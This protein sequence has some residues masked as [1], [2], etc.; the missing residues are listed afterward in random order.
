MK[1]YIFIIWIDIFLF[2]S[3][4]Y[5]FSKDKRL[6]EWQQ[7]LKEHPEFE[8][9]E[10]MWS[11]KNGS[12]YKIT[13]SDN[14]IFEIEEINYKTGNS[15]YAAVTNINEYKFWDSCKY[16]NSK[17]GK[18]KSCSTY[19][20][21]FIDLTEI[22]GI[23]IEN[24]VDVIN[25]YDRI[26]ELAKNIAREQYLN[27]RYEYHIYTEKRNSSISIVSVMEYP[28]YFWHGVAEEDKNDIYFKAKWGENWVEKLNADLPKIRK[29]LGLEN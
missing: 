24:A 18:W 13:L 22:L 27:E 3:I 7:Q 8:T 15:F 28:A 14:R 26:C 2:F 10:Y 19:G 25:N 11:D 16:I 1:K 20:I 23:N 6:P 12:H 21:Y 5:C 17:N 4:C 29:S 9:I